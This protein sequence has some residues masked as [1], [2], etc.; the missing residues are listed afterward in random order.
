MEMAEYQVQRIKEQSDKFYL[1]L[2]PECVNVSFWYIP[3]R[4][5]GI[6]HNKKREQE[7]GKV[8]REILVTLRLLKLILFPDL[9][10]NKGTND[11]EWHLDGGIPARRSSSKLFPINYF[12][13]CS[14]QG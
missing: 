5:R 2:E 1:I 14:H 13:N 12:I 4:L 6:P 10:Y 7:L 3:K 8:M 9:S 11:A